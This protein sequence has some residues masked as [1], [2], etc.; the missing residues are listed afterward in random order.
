MSIHIRSTLRQAW[1]LVYGAKKAYFFGL[2]GLILI[3][4][5]L[6]CVSEEL[7]KHFA[8]ALWIG[9]L[10]TIIMLFCTSPVAAGFAML[11]LKQ[12]QHQPFK[13]NAAFAYFKRIFPLFSVYFI[14]SLVLW[15]SALVILFA[16]L[17]LSMLII[18]PYDWTGHDARLRLTVFVGVSIVT[19]LLCV[20]IYTFFNFS[21]LFI[22]EA[23]QRFYQAIW[24]S[25]RLS[26]AHFKGI[27]GLTLLLF[28]LNCIGTLC[29]GVGLLWTLP[30]TYISMA[31]VYRKF[32]HPASIHTDVN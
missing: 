14:S 11:G 31:L 6:L 7:N 2:V 12:A 22:L 25:I 28:I 26:W 8:N 17:K 19:V 13:W 9:P 30:L 21:F 4:T 24:S 27:Y 18:G 20:A 23:K 15:F 10:M 3:Q 16:L 1:K 32:A 29:F 5:V